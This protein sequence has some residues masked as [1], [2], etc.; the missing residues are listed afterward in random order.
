MSWLAALGS[1]CAIACRICVTSL[2]KVDYIPRER[3]PEG[4]RDGPPGGPGRRRSGSLCLELCRRKA[5]KKNPTAREGMGPDFTN[6]EATVLKDAGARRWAPEQSTPR[7]RFPSCAKQS[8]RLPQRPV[9]V[10]GDLHENN[11][12][13]CH[14]TCGD[15]PCGRRP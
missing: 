4:P 7:Q 3:G 14:N 10:T 12:A 11:C 2:M 15:R 13:E 6:W 8:S 5:G 9:P 1:P